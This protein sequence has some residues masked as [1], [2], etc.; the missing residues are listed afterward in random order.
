MAGDGLGVFELQ[1]VVVRVF[2]HGIVALA[3]GA[4]IGIIRIHPSVES[5]LLLCAEAGGLGLQGVETDL[6]V[7]LLVIVVRKAENRIGEMQAVA[8]LVAAY[9]A[10][11][12]NISVG[13]IAHL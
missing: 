1:G 5:V 4:D 13:N 3:L 12:G 8:L 11:L 2:A 9:P 7:H 10:Q 6:G